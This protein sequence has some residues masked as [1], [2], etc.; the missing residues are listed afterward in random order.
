MAPKHT[1]RNLLRFGLG[2]AALALPVIHAL[3][4]AAS[5]IE[6]DDDL[7]LSDD[8]EMGTLKGQITAEATVIN[9]DGTATQRLIL[10][11]FK[12]TRFMSGWGVLTC[13][14]TGTNWEDAARSQPLGIFEAEGMW[15][16]LVE[17]RDWQAD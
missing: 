16:M 9:A 13:A 1:R 8:P 7:D 4:V 10:M 11:R 2:S 14:P 5:P 17:Q 15:S 3:P 6:D 12:F